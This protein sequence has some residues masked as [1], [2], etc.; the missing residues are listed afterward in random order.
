[1]I[2]KQNECVERGVYKSEKYKCS[3]SCSFDDIQYDYDFI[4]D[5]KEYLVKVTNS[6]S[7]Q[8]KELYM[9]R[10]SSCNEIILRDVYFDCEVFKCHELLLGVTMRYGYKTDMFKHLNI[11]S[12]IDILNKWLNS[13]YYRIELVTDLP[14]SVSGYKYM[15]K[16]K[17]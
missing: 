2:R 6:I 17:W 16:L 7:Q 4:L 11:E 3:E 5:R 10:L 12:T 15:L 13:S 14:I 1:M 9:H 8:I